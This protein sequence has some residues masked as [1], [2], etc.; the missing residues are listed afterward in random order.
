MGDRRG[1][2]SERLTCSAMDALDTALASVRVEGS[3]VGRSLVS[4]PWAMELDSDLPCGLA[5]VVRGD[6]WLRHGDAEPVPLVEGSVVVACGST[7]LHVGDHPDT[8]LGVRVRDREECYDVV[9]GESV[10]ERDRIGSRTWGDPTASGEVVLGAYRTEGA[11]FAL[12]EDELPPALVVGPGTSVSPVLAALV[13][14]TQTERPGQQ[15]VVDRLMELLLFAAVRDWLASPAAA[16]LP[17]WSTALGDPV[18]GPA[19]QAMHD[20]PAR[21]WSVAD[22]AAAAHVSRAGFARRFRALVGEPP[23]AHLTRWRMA[24]AADLLRSDPRLD[25][26]SVAARVGYADAFGFSAAFRRVRGTTPS[27]HRRSA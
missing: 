14:E 5:A 6:A 24:L 22:L 8:P 17:R 7:P 15:V 25:L 1:F 21:R 16:D 23:L 12:L 19:L 9:T 10:A 11:L 4:A 3:M 20:D 13:A 27:A 18:V 26:T 2:L